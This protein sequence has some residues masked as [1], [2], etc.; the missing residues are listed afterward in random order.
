MTDIS[1]F[2]NDFLRGQTDCKEGKP[3]RE[4]QSDAYDLGYGTQ[5]ILNQINDARTVDQFNKINDG[6]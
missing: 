1:N 2:S 5:H 4:G 6:E 3:H